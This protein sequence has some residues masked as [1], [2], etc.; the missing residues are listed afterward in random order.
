[1]VQS[2]GR[3]FVI[4]HPKNCTQLFQFFECMSRL[5]W[6]KLDWFIP[7]F[8]DRKGWEWKGWSFISLNE[9][10]QLFTVAGQELIMEGYEEFKSLITTKSNMTKTRQENLKNSADTLNAK[11][12][13]KSNYWGTFFHIISLLWDLKDNYCTL[14]DFR[15]T[16]ANRTCSAS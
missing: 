6:T 9:K 1:M 3:T 5:D 11:V 16:G 12:I 7:T 2:I 8:L 15:V 10:V 4:V 13:C 14:L